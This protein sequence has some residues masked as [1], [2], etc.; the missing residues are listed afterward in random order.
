MSEE[1]WTKWKE[2]LFSKTL[3]NK[4]RAHKIAYIAVMTALCVVANMFF[5]F[6]VGNITQFSFTIVFSALA[7]ILIGPVFGFTASFLGDVVG[8]LY[9]PKGEYLLWIS[10]SMGLVA[11]LAGFIVNGI[12]SKGNVWIFYGKLVLVSI[13][14]FL[15]CTVAITTTTFWYRYSKVGYLDYL[16]ARL[17]AQ[18]QI[19]NS[20]V[21]YALLFVILPMLNRIKA[22]KIHIN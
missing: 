8:F 21:N 6:P 3:V 13:S 10:I 4:G 12:N 22:L 5:E 2:L 7:G 18:G 19:W 20:I 15:I 1:K 11:L 16:V 9:H 14:T 17:F